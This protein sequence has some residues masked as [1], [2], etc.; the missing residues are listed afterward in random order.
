MPTSRRYGVRRAA[1]AQRSAKGPAFDG[2][3]RLRP[4]CRRARLRAAY[5]DDI[6]LVAVSGFATRDARVGTSFALADHFFT[7]PVD[8]AALAKVLLPLR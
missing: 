4:G 3:R 1:V 5:S 2:S 8:P 6:M 7:Q